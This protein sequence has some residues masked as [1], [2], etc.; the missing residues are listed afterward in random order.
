MIQQDA[1]ARRQ[2]DAERPEVRSGQTQA[3]DR[4]NHGVLQSDVTA[5]MQGEIRKK[6]AALPILPW[7][8]TVGEGP[9][10][11]GDEGAGPV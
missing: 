5:L 9:F 11:R 7:R 3:G 6:E 8:P 1:A 2:P 10:Q 4:E